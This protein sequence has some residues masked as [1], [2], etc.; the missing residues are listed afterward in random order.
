MKPIFEET[1]SNGLLTSEDI[2]KRLFGVSENHG[3]GERILSS[4]YALARITSG[5]SVNLKL[6]ILTVW[7]DKFLSIRNDKFLIDNCLLLKPTLAGLT[8]RHRKEL[9]DFFNIVNIWLDDI[10]NWKEYMKLK[11]FIE[12]VFAYHRYLRSI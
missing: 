3:E 4:A 9:S 8:G 11:N 10:K 7:Y 5:Y 1:I 12:S 2:K 6:T